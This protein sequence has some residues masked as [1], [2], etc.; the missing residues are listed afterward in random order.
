MRN[1]KLVCAALAG[2]SLQACDSSTQAQEEKSFAATGVLAV[3]VDSVIV[4]TYA[5]LA[6][7]A[8]QLE[9]ACARIADSGAT[10]ERVDRA[11]SA[12]LA[13][14]KPWE[15]SE[16]F[17]FGP[18][19]QQGIDPSLDS[20]PV[21]TL[22]MQALL[23]GKEELTSELLQGQDGTVK[24]FHTLERLLWGGEELTPRRAQYLKAAGG[25]LAADAARLH[26]AWT[27][28]TAAQFKAAG[29][30]GSPWASSVSAMQELANGLIGI[31]EEV[32]AGKIG[33]PIE[34]NNPLLEESRF[35]G[36]SLVD[37]QDNILGI[38]DLYLGTRN[39]TVGSGL[40]TLVL[41]LDPA[42][43]ARIRA[44][45]DSA[46]ASIAAIGPSFA[47]GLANNRDGVLAASERSLALMTTIQ[48]KL[49]PLTEKAR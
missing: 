26:R 14:R 32:G 2:I 23:D 17:L 37:F 16:A 25:A 3:S 18:V 5:E 24:G 19:D 9:S 41:E 38:R 35:A 49:L 43:D 21:D 39:G 11:R 36:S 48:A 29:Q 44:D 33:A 22:G 30:A 28:G 13:A 12:W 1:L 40:R 8:A 20:W 45:I 6:S 27:G 31:A 10:T 15:R 34:E 47:Y 4:P 7:A 46:V 42:A